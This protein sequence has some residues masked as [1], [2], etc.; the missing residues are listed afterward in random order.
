MPEQILGT[1]VVVAFLA[2]LVAAGRALYLL[3]KE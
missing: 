3:V 1:L 2:V